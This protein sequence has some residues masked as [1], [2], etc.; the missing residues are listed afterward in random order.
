MLSYQ[1][2][3]HELKVLSSTLIRALFFS[4]GPVEERLPRSEDFG[5]MVMY[6]LLIFVFNWTVR[7]LVVQPLARKLLRPAMPEALKLENFSDGT[8]RALKTRRVARVQKFSQ[9]AM[10]LLFYGFFTYCN[11][12][13]VSR[14]DWSWPSAKWWTGID[15][16]FK[17]KIMPQELA[18]YFLLY[19]GRY[20][21]AVFS[22][23]LEHRR[24]VRIKSST[25]TK[26]MHSSSHG[27]CL[28]LRAG[29]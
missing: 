23:M 7:L 8:I 6:G 5:V 2:C 21:Q 26:L 24:K 10:E 3:Y 4:D 25:V 27:V 20:L 13:I 16:G 9:C 19:G 1:S 28:V 22:V 17:F 15:N 12:V 29:L 18:A 14:Q 11:L